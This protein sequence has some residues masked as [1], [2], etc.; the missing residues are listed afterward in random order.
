MIILA[1]IS[2]RL[3]K[4]YVRWEHLGCLEEV[5]WPECS[6]VCTPEAVSRCW[7]CPRG[8]RCEGGRGRGLRSGTASGAGGWGA[9]SRSSSPSLPSR[10][11]LGAM[12]TNY[13]THLTTSGQ[14]C[15]VLWFLNTFMHKQLIR[16][17]TVWDIRWLCFY[18]TLETLTELAVSVLSLYQSRG[19]SRNLNT[20]MLFQTETLH[21]GMIRLL[22][23]VHGMQKGSV[24]VASCS[25]GSN[26]MSFMNQ[27]Y[28]LSS[29]PWNANRHGSSNTDRKD[30]FVFL[31]FGFCLQQTELQIKVNVYIQHFHPLKMITMSCVRLVKWVIRSSHNSDHLNTFLL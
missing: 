21:R 2:A 25:S 22:H 23:N 18:E 28:V 31:I 6:W 12:T 8:S 16:R 1:L 13:S 7:S 5:S 30:N 29:F 27:F 19:H 20:I 11:T 3:V 14:Q 15:Y 24:I 4:M 17:V 10:S 9:A 26:Q